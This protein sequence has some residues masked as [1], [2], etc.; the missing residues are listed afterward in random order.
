MRNFVWVLAMG[1]AALCAPVR[2]GDAPLS[3]YDM[4]GVWPRHAQLRQD[5]VGAIRRG[6]IRTMESVCRSALELMPRDATWQYNLACA[7]AYRETPD[8]ALDAL[9]KAIDW[10]FRDANQMAKDSDL[11]RLAQ[12][13]RFPKLIEKARALAGKPVDGVPVAA[14]A[15][16]PAGDALTLAE[17]NLVWNFDLGVFNALVNLKE[18]RRALSDLAAGYGASQGTGPERPYVA[19]WLSEGTGAG[20]TGDLYVNRDG[21][22]SAIRVSDFPNLTAVRHAPAPG[23]PN[24]FLD[25]PNELYGGVPVFGNISR[26]RL[27]GL[28]W[29]SFAREAMTSPGNAPRMDLFYRDNQFWV[30]PCLNDYGNPAIG[31]VFPCAAPFQLVTLGRSWSDLPFVRAA[32]AAS[33]SFRRPTKQA[34]VRRRLLGPTLQYLLRR[35]RKCVASDADYLTAKAHPTVFDAKELDLVALVHRAHDMKMED[36]P[37]AVN[38][39]LV[40][41]TLFPVR[42]PTP[43]RDYPDTPSELLFATPSAICLVLR[44]PE[45]TR[46]FIFRATTAPE[47]DPTADFVWRVVHGDA[48]AVKIAAPLGETVNT[49]ERGFA[50]ITIDRRALKGRIDV[51]CFARSHGTPYGA[52]SIISFTP[53]SLETRVYRAD[54]KL[55]SID[56]TNPNAVYCDPMIALPRQWKDTYEYGADG[57]CTG[58]VRSY[59]GKPAASFLPTGERV[60]ARGADGAP[61]RAVRVK[62]TTR[63]TGDQIQPYELTYT[64]DGEPFDLL[65][66]R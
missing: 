38:L 51:A 16:V 17:T 29:R 34:I 44:A 42:Y 36:V 37:P 60:V 62:Y 22:H 40:N 9:D 66:A 2:A 49:P 11:A 45:G 14:P 46:D 65:S 31:D 7:L 20:N 13:G 32:L 5:L 59:N 27:S 61:T 57:K 48:K 1:L 23:H 18:P 47:N 52:P 35:T 28:F 25:L 15:S 50:Q 33:A 54:G 43:G 6:D 55:D 4:P 10:G 19:A 8:Q 30:I 3:V 12:D 56:Y 24:L 39:G 21:G 53:V 26:G 41:S 58:Y 63:A 64:D